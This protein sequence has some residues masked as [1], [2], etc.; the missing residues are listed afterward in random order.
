MSTEIIGSFARP[1]KVSSSFSMNARLPVIILGAMAFAAEPIALSKV[2][3]VTIIKPQFIA[4]FCIV[5]V[6]APSHRLGMMKA[7]LR[8]FLLQLPFLSIHL[9]GGMTVAAGK[10]S[11]CHWRRSDW[12]LF[13]CPAREGRKTDP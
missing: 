1:H 12:E 8:V 11:L 2:Y 7:D 4:V 9:Q 10:H 3:E 6:E 5:A 13:T